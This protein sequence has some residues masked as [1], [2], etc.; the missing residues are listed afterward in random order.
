[1]DRGIWISWYNLQDKSRDAYLDWLHSTYIPKQLARPGFTWA[2]HYASLDNVKLSGAKGRLSN[3]KNNAVPS[4]DRYILLFGGN[5]AH[6]FV[7]PTPAEFHAQMPAADRKM[8]ALRLGERS[9]IMAEEARIHGPAATQPL[10]QIA[11]SP[12]IQI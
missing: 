12:C 2:A 11:L 9:N 6:A 4:G 8:L 1:M 3:V 7:R 10:D 5:D